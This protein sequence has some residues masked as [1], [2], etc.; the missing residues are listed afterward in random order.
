MA[1]KEAI[2]SELISFGKHSGK[3]ATSQTNEVRTRI[4]D[5]DCKY[6]GTLDELLIK[7]LINPLSA[8][9]Y[10]TPPPK[11]RDHIINTST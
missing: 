3:M 4:P 10:D 6:D 11:H 9:V 2:R 7:P 5:L 1:T 8:I